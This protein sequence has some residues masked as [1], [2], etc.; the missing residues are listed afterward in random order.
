MADFTTSPTR[1]TGGW[2]IGAIVIGLIILFVIFADGSLPPAEQGTTTAEPEGIA[3]A[4]PVAT[5]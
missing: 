4:A 1:S 3:P 5:E 2:I